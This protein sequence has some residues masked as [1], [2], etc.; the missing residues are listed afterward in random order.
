M[1]DYRELSGPEIVCVTTYNCCANAIRDNLSK[2]EKRLK[3][4]GRE[5]LM[6]R[7]NEAADI[8]SD[9][10]QLMIEESPDEDQRKMILT[11][12]SRL[13]IQFGH[14]R[15]HP[16]ELVIMT[17]NDSQLLLAPLLDRCDLEC[18]CVEYDAGGDRSVN[19]ELVKRCEV[20]KALKRI[21]V[22]ETGLGAEC[23]YQYLTGGKWNG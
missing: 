12:M 3:R 13:F 5:D 15:K 6:S 7:L 4:M 21:G 1:K 18:P 9:F 14:Y 8:L 22:S 17:L 20:R 10:V 11:R 2:V 19:R 16:E 23:K